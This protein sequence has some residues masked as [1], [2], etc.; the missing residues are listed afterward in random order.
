IPDLVQRNA[1]GIDTLCAVLN[2]PNAAL[3][4]K[5]VKRRLLEDVLPDLGVSLSS[6]TDDPTSRIVFDYATGGLLALMAYRA[7]TGFAYPVETFLH[8]L[9]PEVPAALLDVL[10]EKR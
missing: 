9:A 1:Q 8:C 4:Q 6:N 7:E 5:R 3:A 2:G 10:S